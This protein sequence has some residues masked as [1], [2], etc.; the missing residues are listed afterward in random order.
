MR[1]PYTV[2]IK[3]TITDNDGKRVT[4]VPVYIRS[5]SFS[6]MFDRAVRLGNALMRLT[7]AGAVASY[8]VVLQCEDEQP[9]QE[10][11]Q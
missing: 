2:G 9:V 6:D 4:S 5:E 8:A 7:E 3:L 10:A 1:M 11:G